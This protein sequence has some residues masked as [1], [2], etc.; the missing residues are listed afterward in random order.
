VIVKERAAREASPL[1][2]AKKAMTKRNAL[3]V[4]DAYSYDRAERSRGWRWRSTAS[5][6]ARERE[7]T[8]QNLHKSL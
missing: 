3:L 1:L 5:T 6:K 2:G 7:S 4:G 8:R